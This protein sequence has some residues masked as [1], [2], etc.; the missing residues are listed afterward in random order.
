MVLTTLTLKNDYWETFELN[1]DDLERI[2]DHLLEIETPLTP[3][4]LSTVLVENRIED[5]KKAAEM[6]QS[7]GGKPYLPK[8]V[9]AEGEKI[10]FPTLNWEAG[11]VTRVRDP[12]TYDDIEYKVIE[13]EFES[14]E[15]REYASG[16][17]EHALN[18]P[19][20]MG[21]EDPLM[22]PISVMENYGTLIS[23]K[24]V[25]VLKDNE[26]FVYIAGRWFPRALLVDRSMANRSCHSI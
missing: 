25:S 14:G 17:A 7:E 2:Y 23:Q 12:K 18:E 3:K 13:V 26:D 21:E 19:V 16:L 1:E 9:Y 4:E 22:N 8:E 6:K 5:E 11:V 20:E 24:L 10:V 15:K